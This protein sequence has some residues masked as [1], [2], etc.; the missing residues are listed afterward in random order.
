[1]YGS[2]PSTFTEK[3]RPHKRSMYVYFMVMCFVL[4][5]CTIYTI[6]KLLSN[7]P[8]AVY[9]PTKFTRE[10]RQITTLKSKYLKKRSV[11][12]FPEQMT[13]SNMFNIDE[14]LFEENFDPDVHFLTHE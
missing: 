3:L 8:M 9:G 11:V 13:S 10:W 14:S 7:D 6:H 5:A 4:V 12:I 2:V 1:M